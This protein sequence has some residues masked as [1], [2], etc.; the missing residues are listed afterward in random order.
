MPVRLASITTGPVAQIRG[1]N[2][3]NAIFTPQ[4]GCP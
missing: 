4:G 2:M 1:V 3:D